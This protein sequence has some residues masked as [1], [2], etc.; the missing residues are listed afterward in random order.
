MSCG[1]KSNNDNSS[2]KL[3]TKTDILDVITGTWQTID[4][5]SEMAFVFTIEDNKWSD[6]FHA[7]NEIEPSDIEISDNYL[8]RKSKLFGSDSFEVVSYSSSELVL[9]HTN[10]NLETRFVRPK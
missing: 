8:I 5:E 1:N 10:T 2:Q 3:E 4:Q 7:E 6:A 9:K